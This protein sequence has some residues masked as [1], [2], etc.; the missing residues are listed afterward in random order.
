MRDD[1]FKYSKNDSVTVRELY[2]LV[3]SKMSEAN[4]SISRVEDKV[5]GLGSGRISNIEIKLSNL[6]GRAM[7][8]PFLITTALNVI[9]FILEWVILKGQ[10]K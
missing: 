6:E 5:D 4:K 10:G 9:F 1:D 7:M 2:T 3:D 8:I